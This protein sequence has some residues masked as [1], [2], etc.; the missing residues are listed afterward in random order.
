[1]VTRQ[2]LYPY[3][4]APLLKGSPVH[5][6]PTCAGSREW[7]NH[8]GSYVYRLSVHFYNRLFPGLEPVSIHVWDE[9]QVG[10]QQVTINFQQYA[11][12]KKCSYNNKQ[13]GL[14]IVSIGYY[15]IAN[16]KLPLLDI[17]THQRTN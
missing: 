11:P 4:K 7:S 6:A 10:V 13:Y 15:S 1:M 9:I 8:F 16:V 2:Q 12:P 5:V 14:S 3:A 17:C